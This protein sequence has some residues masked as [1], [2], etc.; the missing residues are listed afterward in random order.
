MRDS[1]FIDLVKRE[2]LA[3][4]NRDGRPLAPF[5]EA[6][7]MSGLEIAASAAVSARFSPDP[8]PVPIIAL[9][10]SR[11]AA[12]TSE[13]QIDRASLTIRSVM[14]AT[15]KRSWSAMAKASA[16]VVFSLVHP[17]QVLI[18]DDQQRIDDLLQF[19]D[20]GFG[21]AHAALAFELKR[22]GDHADREGAELPRG[23]GD[24]RCCAGAGAAAHSGGDE[25]H[26]CASQVIADFIDHLFG[27]G[28]P[29]LGLRAG[30]KT[31][32]RLSA[33]SG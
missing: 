6:S 14:Q 24:D 22:L 7:S 31:L 12:R 29:R 30:A 15:A 3:A 20:A 16:K 17:E 27:G 18:R 26:M 28:T 11:V 5:I 2:V 25:H 9:P 32:R 13:S 10:I 8:S 19:D 4:R 1:G 21:K 23:F 33:P